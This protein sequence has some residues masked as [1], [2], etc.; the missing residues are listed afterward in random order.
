[1]EATLRVLVPLILVVMVLKA[2]DL[3]LRRHRV[4]RRQPKRASAAQEA[5]PT[6]AAQEPEPTGEP[7][8]L[9]GPL[10]RRPYHL[11]TSFLSPAEH[12]FFLVLSHTVGDWAIVCPKVNLADIFVSQTGNAQQDLRYKNRIDRKHVDFLLC[13]PHSARP[14]AGVELDD[15]SHRRPERQDRDVFVQEVFDAAGLPLLRVPVKPGYSPL[16]LLGRLRL[17]AHPVFEPACA[18]QAEAEGL[19][20]MLA[21]PLPPLAEPGSLDAPACPLCG[22]AMV[23]RVSRKGPNPGE[24]FWGCPGY[25]NCRGI[26]KLEVTAPLPQGGAAL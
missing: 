1:M 22:Q 11:R 9:A 21:S 26:R 19:P 15:S 8:W 14:L 4:R 17:E 25:P 20:P 13:D 18:D 6:R 24:R 2:V 5:G 7:G 23:P 16:E 3:L 10:D 12:S